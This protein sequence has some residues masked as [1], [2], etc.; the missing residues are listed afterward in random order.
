MPVLEFVCLPWSEVCSARVTSLLLLLLLLFITIMEESILWKEKNIFRFNFFFFATRILGHVQPVGR[1][2]GT[3]IC[4]AM[5]IW[6]M[7]RTKEAITAMR[8]TIWA[9]IV[10]GQLEPRVLFQLIIIIIKGHSLRRACLQPATITQNSKPRPP[11]TNAR[12]KGKLENKIKHC[13][14]LSTG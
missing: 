14:K 7:P 5:R 10:A 2:G 3:W 9:G 1:P 13:S 11:T 6:D 8:R 4:Y 12:S